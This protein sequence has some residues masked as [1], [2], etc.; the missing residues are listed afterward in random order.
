MYSDEIVNM[1][2]IGC[3]L[4]ARSFPKM[5]TR[6]GEQLKLF[7]TMCNMMLAVVMLGYNMMRVF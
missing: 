1:C 2:F 6:R 3:L 7:I 5:D 4:L